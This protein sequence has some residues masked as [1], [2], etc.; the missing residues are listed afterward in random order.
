MVAEA[1]LVGMFALA[2]IRVIDGDSLVVNGV[3]TR[4]WGIDAPEYRQQC[5]YERRETQCGEMAAQVMRVLVTGRDVKCRK[6]DADRGRAV[7]V[8]SVEGYDLGG[9]MVRLGW[10]LDYTYH[11]KGYYKHLENAAKAERR[12]IWAM[13]F[14]NPREWRVQKKLN[15]PRP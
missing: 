11:T 13:K 3:E 7:S 4:I 5:V 9:Y 2:D 15:T 10:A 12:G 8:C 14:L 6:V 1:L